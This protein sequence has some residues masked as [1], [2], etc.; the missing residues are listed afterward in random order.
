MTTQK[1]T[2]LVHQRSNFG[3]QLNPQKDRMPG[4]SDQPAD[5]ALLPMNFTSSTLGGHERVL[6]FD[7]NTSKM[8]LSIH[9]APTK[10]PRVGGYPGS[11]SKHTPVTP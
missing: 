4:R 2:V 9:T 1:H 11:G 7:Q 3:L 6:N 8:T 5:L 10:F